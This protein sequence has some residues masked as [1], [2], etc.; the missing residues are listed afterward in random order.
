MHGAIGKFVNWFCT[1]SVCYFFA[2]FMRLL[3]N[4]INC[5]ASFRMQLKQLTNVLRQ[6][7][8]L[9]YETATIGDW[10]LT[11]L[12]RGVKTMILCKTMKFEI[13]ELW[14]EE[15]ANQG[16]NWSDEFKTIKFVSDESKILFSLQWFVV[17]YCTDN[18]RPSR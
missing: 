10:N 14:S 11:F 3:P 17:Q 5:F 7:H 18:F 6:R 8:S 9:L 4:V 16:A 2:I 1:M 15:S 13:G 12:S